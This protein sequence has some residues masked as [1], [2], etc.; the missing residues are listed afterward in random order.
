MEKLANDNATSADFDLSVVLRPFVS[1]VEDHFGADKL[2]EILEVSGLERANIHGP[3]HWG[4]V[5]QVDTFYALT[6]ELLGRDDQRFIDAAAY[7]MA[8]TLTNQIISGIDLC[9]LLFKVTT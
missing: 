6:Y 3:A 7:N 4:S 1:Y 5:E 8:Q 2:N 9:I